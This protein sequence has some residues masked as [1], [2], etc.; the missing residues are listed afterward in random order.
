MGSPSDVPRAANA[1]DFVIGIADE[2]ESADVKQRWQGHSIEDFNGHIQALSEVKPTLPAEY[3]MLSVEGRQ[4]H[5]LLVTI[6]KSAEVHRTAANDVYQRKGAQ[7]LKLTNDQIQQLSFAKGAT[8]F[9]DYTVSSTRAEE[10][11]ESGQITSFLASY[12]PHTEPLEFAL[13]QNL[14]DRTSLDPRVAGIILFCD[15]PA[16]FMPRKCS[17]RITRYTTKNEDTLNAIT[18]NRVKL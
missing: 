4:G 13:N 15:N 8:T 1:C 9:E 17:V 7:S 12:A 6:E 3:T 18:S 5:A 11:F 16:A 14:L 10:V 2:K